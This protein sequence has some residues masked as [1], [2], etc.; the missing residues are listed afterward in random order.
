MVVVCRHGS[1]LGAER[2]IKEVTHSFC[3]IY[4]EDDAI[5]D[6]HAGCDLVREVNVAFE[7]DTKH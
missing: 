3:C 2:K 5:G 4:E 7:G 6:P 1:E